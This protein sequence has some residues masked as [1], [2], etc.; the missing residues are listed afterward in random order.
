MVAVAIVGLVLIPLLVL[1]A[2]L[3][4]L[5]VSFRQPLVGAIYSAVC[6]LGIAA[7]F[8]PGK[9][10][11]LFG[12]PQNPMP[13]VSGRSN[14]LRMSGHH[15]DCQNFAGN[16]IK[17]G[18]RVFCAACSGLLIGAVIALVGVSL[19]FFVGLSL[20]WGSGWLLL[21]GEIGMGLGLAQIKLAGY[22][23]VI[24]NMVFV[25]GSF[26]ILAEADLLGG[27]LLV[28]FYVLGL[29]VFLLWLRILFSERNNRRICQTCQSCFQ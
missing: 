22:A 5:Q 10:R 14:S 15:P 4:D 1:Q 27:S 7:A 6:V 16:R 21:A 8:Y 25:V 24:S 19:Q 29:I 12:N 11:G 20:V 3:M 13:Q 23:K 17:M 28:D 9:C 26:V 2:D 18:S